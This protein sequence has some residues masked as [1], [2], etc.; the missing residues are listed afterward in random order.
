VRAAGRWRWRR[1]ALVGSL[2]VG[3][4][5]CGD[6]GTSVYTPVASI[7]FPDPV[8]EACARETARTYGWPTAGR[9]ETLHC[10]GARG[11]K[12]TSLQGI[13]VLG[14]LTDLALA[15][16]QINAV[17]PLL[18]L[19]KLARL[20]LGF[21]SLQRIEALP[22]TQHLDL[23]H[24]Q[25]ADLTF[26][27]SS[28]NIRTLLLEYNRLEDLEPLRGLEFLVELQVSGNRITGFRTN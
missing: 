9:V 21:N 6:S 10:S 24:N 26:V 14:N 8:L 1:T 17:E 7:A 27:A 20:D 28:P 19:R 5:A 11:P 13:A 15:H 25:L 4:A 23:N 16:N 3:L 18:G 2:L 22:W 12:I